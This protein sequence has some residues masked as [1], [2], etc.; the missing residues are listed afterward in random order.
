[1]KKL[2]I[3]IF[4]LFTAGFLLTSC[5]KNDDAEKFSTLSVEQNKAI[6][7][8]SGID[9]VNAMGRME[10]LE[11][12]EVLV[13][14]G[15]LNSKSGKSCMVL[16]EGSKLASVFHALANATNGKRDLDG[17][18]DAMISP[19]E[20]KSEDPESIQE[21]WNDNVG[22]YTWN[23]TTSDWD[24]VYGGNKL[25]FLFPAT[26][27]SL[28]NNATIT[29]YNY[30]GVQ[31]ANPIDDDY[32]GDLPAALNA[33]LKVGSKTL[34]SFVYGASYNNDGV[35]KSVAVDLTIETFKFEVDITNDTKVVSVNYKFLE[36]GNTILDMGATGHGLF[37]E[38]NYDANTVHHTET[39]SYVCNYVW[40]S[41][42]QTW[43]YVYCEDTDEWDE[44]EFEEILN[45]A[46]AHFQLFSIALKGEI[47]VKG[48]T[49]QIRV[50]E[51]QY[52]KEKITDAVRD[53]R[54]AEQ[55]NKFLNLRLVN[56]AKNEIIA[57]AEAYVVHESDY[58]DDW[59]YVDFRLTFGDGSPV[60]METY[61]DT[62]FDTFVDEINDLIYDINTDYDA[63]IDYID[64]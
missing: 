21:W 31:I 47:D 48:L 49:D 7:E 5:K 6:V 40:N 51:D 60:D 28:T 9:F 52:D 15:N 13:N 16:S 14:L 17:V 34:V 56:I 27:N 25:I 37:T 1:M 4:L 44:T 41:Y 63:D 36:N 59:T 43:D 2:F 35:P 11:T 23:K 57:K 64:Y 50:I 29:I 20:L 61:F 54:T 33:D 19:R 26:E 45:S 42:T 10:S 18:Y 12:I 58:Y 24:I 22:T 30:A 32:S 3:S 39:Y 8:D 55:I 62:G 53:Q 46:E 38:D